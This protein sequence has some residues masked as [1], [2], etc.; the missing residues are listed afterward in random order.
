MDPTAALEVLTVS[1]LNRQAKR[2][3]ENNFTP[4]WLE[5][6][7]SNFTHHRSGHMYFA[8]KDEQAQVSAV[9]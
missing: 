8:L 5:G 2:L 9:M 3:L 1:E 4:V 7:I 6:E